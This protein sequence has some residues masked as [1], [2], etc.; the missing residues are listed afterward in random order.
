M[1][2]QNGRTALVTGASSGIG[3]A[4]AQLL[5]S[6]GYSLVITARRKERLTALAGELKAE[7]GTQVTVLAADLADPKTPA[8]M[9]A[10]LNKKGIHID[11]LVNNAGFGGDKP[12][13]KT[14]WAELQGELQLMVVAVTELMHLF[15][16]AMVEKGWGRVLNV[17]SVAGYAPI[18]NGLLYSGTKSYLVNVSQA[19]DMELHKKGVFVTALCP[20][21]TETEFFEVQGSTESANQMP[22]FAKQ[23]AEDV[24]KIG[25]DALMA[26]KP[27]IVPGVVN[28]VMVSLS[29]HT[30]EAIR[31]QMGKRLKFK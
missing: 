29:R 12:F 6:E 24:A 19:V 26:G 23:S 1:A 18:M 5:A 20:G 9:L 11:M 8:K 10:D 22:K 3:K 25:Y 7:H 14:G 31:Y 15:T 21:L 27:V 17:A 30:P 4:Y 13:L 16:P 2:T 28:K